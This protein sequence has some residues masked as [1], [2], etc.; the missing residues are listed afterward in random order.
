MGTQVAQDTVKQAEN[1]SKWVARIE[2]ESYP[3]TTIF[4]V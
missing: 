1:K 2:I 3:S 4:N